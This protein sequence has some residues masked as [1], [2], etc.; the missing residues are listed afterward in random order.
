MKLRFQVNGTKMHSGRLIGVWS[1]LQ[2]GDRV[3]ARLKYNKPAQNTQHHF[4][5]DP[6]L[7]NVVDFQ[8]PFVHPRSYI[9]PLNP[10]GL[11]QLGTFT[12]RVYNVL[13]TGDT[14]TNNVN[15]SLTIMFPDA[16]VHVPVGTYGETEMRQ[17]TAER[18][19]NTI[20]TN[21]NFQGAKEITLGQEITGDEF[22]RG[23]SLDASALDKPNNTL[24]AYPILL[25]A[26]GYMSH[27]QNIPALERLALQPGKVSR[28]RREYAGTKI[29]EMSFDF[30][31]RIWAFDRKITITTTDN[32]N[33][34]IAKDFI[35]PLA[36]ALS[37]GWK[38]NIKFYPTNFD[39]WSFPFDY[40]SGGIE[41]K[42][43]VV[44][45]SFHVCKLF[46]GIHY[47]DYDVPANI[48]DATTEYG[49]YI[50][51]NEAKHEFD[52]TV[53]YISDTPALRMPTGRIGG[54]FGSSQNQDYSMGTW[55]LRIVNPLVAPTGTST[56]IDINIYTRAAEDYKTYYMTSGLATARNETFTAYKQ[57]E[58]GGGVSLG[59]SEKPHT[60]SEFGEEYTSIKEILKRFTFANRIFSANAATI[61]RYNIPSLM[62][63][64]SPNV[65]YHTG[66][67][68]GLW[69]WSSSCY[70]G[71][72]GSLRF[73]VYNQFDPAMVGS[74][75][76][77]YVPMGL[78]DTTGS[79]YTT[80]SAWVNNYDKYVTRL[81][82][83]RA[84]HIFTDLAAR[85]VTTEQA[86]GVNLVEVPFVSG[87]NFIRT[88]PCYSEP[89][90]NGVR[91]EFTAGT[92][93]ATTNGSGVAVDPGLARSLYFAA[94]DE[95]RFIIYLGPVGVQI[96]NELFPYS[97]L[98]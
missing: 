39:Y 7:S 26:M 34:I 78:L 79:P 87:Y 6:A 71:M 13:R 97:Y 48:G 11:A 47:G 58:I 23:V 74:S 9:R 93:I 17:F 54:G 85:N 25:N 61:T 3:E 66:Y 75:T 8:I 14:T 60:H 92:L 90:Q 65:D 50:D 5:L 2:T 67:R 68:T 55:S 28:V 53:K 45:S 81:E 15:V 16:D 30:V 35:A 42:I 21:N 20:T 98:V 59:T 49:A 76:V 91:D 51:I 41:Y 44:C 89:L 72:R 62:D 22:G 4:M 94:G 86:S 82:L 95:F 69:Q 80:E 70:A 1:P 10:T 18:Q 27:S 40:W 84:D 19:G 12:L 56:S 32:N 36:Q 96:S 37:G 88:Q 57:G 64:E 52:F 29:D 46:F 43:E 63:V 73:K 24:E 83:S 31:R 33:T 77:S 38:S